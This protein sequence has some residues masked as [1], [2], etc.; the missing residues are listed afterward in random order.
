MTP[1]KSH[2]QI[3]P[4]HSLRSDGRLLEESRFRVYIIEA[5]TTFS[6]FVSVYKAAKDCLLAVLVLVLVLEY[7]C[8]SHPRRAPESEPRPELSHAGDGTCTTGEHLI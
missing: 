1:F 7:R 3:T 5:Y 4:Y 2:P 6:T 8:V